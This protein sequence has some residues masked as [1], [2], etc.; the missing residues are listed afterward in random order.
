MNTNEPMQ[1]SR[2]AG[3]GE[4]LPDAQTKPGTGHRKAARDY[5]GVL[6]DL[7]RYRAD[8]RRDD[9]QWLFQQCRLGVLGVGPAWNA[10]GCRTNQ[11]AL[12][13][14]Q[15]SP[16]AAEFPALLELPRRFKPEDAA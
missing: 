14:V 16:M 1:V 8:L 7:G 2:E 10:I 15:R 12:I 3:N 4:G 13:R 11:N 6:I 5:R 9:L